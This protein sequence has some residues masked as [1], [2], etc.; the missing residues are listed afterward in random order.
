[1]S[2]VAACGGDF[3][4][5]RSRIYASVYLSEWPSLLESDQHP[6]LGPKR[7]L[8]KRLTCMLKF[9]RVVTKG[10]EWSRKLWGGLSWRGS[11]NFDKVLGSPSLNMGLLLGAKG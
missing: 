8:A 3:R 10:N 11:R 9:R 1:M 4:V 6:V 5:A 2:Q 7:R